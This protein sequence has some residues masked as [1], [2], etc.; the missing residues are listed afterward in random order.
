MSEI[1][2]I[3]T[4]VV[5]L[6]AMLLVGFAYSKTN[7]DSADF[8]L[9]GRK[10]GP[11]VTAMSAEASDM[12]SWLLMGMPGLAYLTGIASPGWTAIGLALGT[13]LNWLIVARRLRRYSANLD[14]ITVPQF[15]SLRFHDQRN[16]LNALGAVII[17]VFF[18]PYTASGFAACGK[19][20]HSL[21]GIDYMAA[22]LVSAL[23]IVGYTI[24]GGFRAVTTTDLIQ[25]VVMSLAL[26]AVLGYGIVVA[27]G[28]GAVVENAQS[29][30]GY[31]TMTAS[32]DAV[33][34]GAASY[35]LLDIVSTMAWGLGYFG[36]PHIL[37]RFMAIEDE[38]KL[39]LSRRIATVWVVI[40][41]T[42]SI[43]IGMVGLGMTRVGALEFLSG[44][45]SETLIVHIAS[46]I[47][48]HGVLA[49]VLAGLILAG[50]LAATMS[51][52]DSQML[53]AASS[54]SQDLMQHSF[55]IK[56]NQR[57]TMLA[58]RATV[59]CIA[60]IG[61][62]LAWDP[63]SSV[64]R[65]VSFAWAGFGAA[66]GPV[67]LFSLFWKRANKQGALAGMITGGAVVFIWKYL[68]APMGGAWAIYELLPAFLAACIAI[69][70][71]SLATP[72]PEKAVTDTFDEICGK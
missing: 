36:M 45:S 52:A 72:A 69:V 35:S 8:Y 64:F 21:F 38:K 20:F 27:G 29:L 47:S 12:S 3:V 5:Y 17:I 43:V 54:V 44:S 46:L 66:F 22:M 49:A 34:G 65:V 41:M 7:N 68:I 67:M 55:G 10:M 57:T 2:I 4:I 30:S 24:L 14:A 19:L 61:M 9:G 48:Q 28:W 50:I 62:V 40:A 23:V 11:L 6:A 31:L 15:L 1:C 26:I 58:A 13:W 56:M 16:L 42:A 70:I 18:V 32:H 33:T 59:I 53:A 63:N 71:V 51:T 37:L 25:S 39:V 60:I